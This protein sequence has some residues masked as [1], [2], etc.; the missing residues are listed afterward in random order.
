M[1]PCY[2]IYTNVESKDCP[3]TLLVSFW[4][5]FGSCRDARRH[6]RNEW[7]YSHRHRG[8]ITRNLL[9]LGD[10]AA[11]LTE[12]WFRLFADWSAEGILPV[13]WQTTS[14]EI[15]LQQRVASQDV[16]GR[17]EGKWLFHLWRVGGG[18]GGGG[19]RYSSNFNKEH[20]HRCEI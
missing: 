14:Q 2:E 20:G 1:Q 17:A 3:E 10:D 5:M 13:R 11:K 15:P 16:E 18:R 19:G 9:I 6:E 7:R 4:E 8:V 12:G